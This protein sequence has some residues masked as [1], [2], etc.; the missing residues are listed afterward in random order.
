MG[1][2]ERVNEDIKHGT[3][4]HKYHIP[5]YL[6]DWSLKLVTKSFREK[7]LVILSLAL[8]EFGK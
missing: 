6:R 3:L 8:S 4:P 7:I 2:F 1:Y 5:L